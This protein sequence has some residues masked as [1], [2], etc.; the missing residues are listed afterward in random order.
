M[1]AALNL[2]E[3]YDEK[4]KPAVFGQ[5]DS[6]FPEFGFKSTRSGWAASNNEHTKRVF[7]CRADRV[8]CNSD[9][10]SGGAPAGF[11]VHGTDTHLLFTSY[12]NGGLKPTDHEFKEIVIDLAKRV[13]VQAEISA[14]AQEQDRI[15]RERV[16]RE[17]ERTA[18]AHSRID[19]EVL[20]Y[21]H[22]RSLGVAPPADIGSEGGKLYGAVRDARG[23]I[24]GSFVRAL[25][26]SLPK[27]KYSDDLRWEDIVATNMQP[28]RESKEARFVE[29]I[30]EPFVLSPHGIEVQSVGG[31]LNKLTTDKWERLI[32]QGIKTAWLGYDNDVE[33]IKGLKAA[34]ENYRSMDQDDL[35][36]LRVPDVA[37]FQG[38]KDTGEMLV[39]FGGVS[40]IHTLFANSIHHYEWLAKQLV[41]EHRGNGWTSIN[42]AKCIAAALQVMRATTPKQWPFMKL[43]F[44]GYL[45]KNIEGYE[46]C[47]LEVEKQI[48]KEREAKE[49]EA[50]IRAVLERVRGVLDGTVERSEVDLGGLAEDVDAL[51]HT[52]SQST[53]TRDVIREHL[54]RVEQFRGRADR[55]I[56]LA[57][58]GIPALDSATCGL[59]GVTLFVAPPNI[60]KTALGWQIGLDIL[61]TNPTAGFF[62]VGLEMSSDSM[63]AR[64]ICNFAG[65]AYRD[66]LFGPHSY[67]QTES[68]E[69]AIA[70]LSELAPRLLMLGPDDIAGKSLKEV[71]KMVIEWKESQ[72][73]TAVY[74]LFDYL[75]KLKP[76]KKQRK[77]MTDAEIEEWRLEE[78][79]HLR[80]SEDEP[81]I[82]ICQKRK[83]G[84]DRGAG[85][86]NELDS[87]KGTASNSYDAEMMFIGNLAEDDE[88]RDWLNVKAG[89]ELP[90]PNKAEDSR[91]QMGDWHR[92]LVESGRR[93]VN[94]A[95]AKGRDGVEQTVIPLTYYFRENKFREGWEWDELWK[96]AEQRAHLSAVPKDS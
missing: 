19:A 37:D 25:D 56:G 40:E 8:V 58:H 17:R 3:L 59:R 72:G 96:N 67:R 14:A 28:A 85:W 75:Q 63:V 46:Q 47:K 92:K 33:G 51:S 12:L 66:Y 34:L 36:D 78:I 11:F 80:I 81:V 41:R 88:L 70:R 61:K 60:G 13:G 48:L 2:Y 18:E 64:A 95:I 44:E 22:S 26:G 83:A 91:R 16:E 52:R 4:I 84:T 20:D 74:G 6:V 71:R 65:I 31:A 7:G 94:L 54:Q 43:N 68:I 9:R 29:G 50:N 73:L 10:R 87:A 86:Q 21:W 53:H 27:Y 35:V 49:H 57:Q 24:V 69:R 32:K 76:S 1:D 23:Q 62:C 79:K 82:V 45:L 93:F 77:G 90:R 55:I 39:T 5:L 30:L 42:L 89:Q 15:R 38:C